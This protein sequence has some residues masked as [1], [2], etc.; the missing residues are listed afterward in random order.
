MVQYT[1]L[2]TEED[3]FAVKVSISP[4]YIF[5]TDLELTLPV[6]LWDNAVQNSEVASSEFL[7]TSLNTYT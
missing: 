6:D 3:N 1:L 5:C 2:S 4:L 7:S